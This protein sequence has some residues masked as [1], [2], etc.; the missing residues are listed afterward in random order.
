VL[1]VDEKNLREHYVLNVTFVIITTN[2]KQNGIYLPADD[3]RHYVAW[4]NLR[5]EDFDAEYWNR[6]YAWYDCGGSEAIAAYL[7]DLDIS[8]FNP[9]APPTK[10]RAWWEIVDAS[11]APE[12]AELADALD[13]LE[14]PDATTLT[15]IRNRVTS[16][17]FAEWLGD[18]KNAR[19]IPHRLEE[20]GYIPHRNSGAA[21]GLWK[22]QGR[23]MAVY[24][25]RELSERDATVAVRK[26]GDAA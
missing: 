9:K 23:R 19:M 26:L 18:R 16:A 12:D 17:E 11:R 6:M 2:H 4:S 21:D 3:R 25:K 15:A 8:N 22:I 20:C 24:V 13:Q 10:T 1:R 5:K 14:R 7:R